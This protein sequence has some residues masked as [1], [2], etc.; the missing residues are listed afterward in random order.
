MA[1]AWRSASN[2]AM[3]WFGVHAR[4]DDLQRHL[5]ADGLD[6][7]GHVDDAH[8]AFADLLQQLVGADD[9]PGVL[10]CGGLIRG[11]LK[12]NGGHPIEEAPSSD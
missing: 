5:A 6:L 8:A 10:G 4:L 11:Y 1:S 7:L 2:R 3:T 9:R 12:V